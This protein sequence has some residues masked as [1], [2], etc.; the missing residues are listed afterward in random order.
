MS[1]AH[2]IAW[3]LTNGP[4]PAGLFVCHHCDTPGC[5]RPD[6]LFLGTA[7]ENMQDA[8]RKDRMLHGTK[9]HACHRGVPAE[10]AEHVKS[11]DGGCVLA[12]LVPGH[13]CRDRWGN[14]HEPTRL[15]LCT[16]E[17]VKSEMGTGRRAPSDAHHLVIACY[18]SNA[19]T[20]ETSKYRPLIRE[21]LAKHEPRG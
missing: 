11:R 8:S 6:H 21:Y 7:Q 10:I 5:V 1:G 17:H 9:W 19:F 3:E 4:I 18:H 13:V 20:V 15:D 14:V 2:R 16:F 12:R